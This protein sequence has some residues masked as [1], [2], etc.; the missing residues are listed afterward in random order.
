V[1]VARM[2]SLP[3]PECCD[4]RLFEQPFCEDD[5]GQDC[6]EWLCVDCGYALMMGTYPEFDVPATRRAPVLISDRSA[7]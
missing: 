4:E 7:A 2:L 1:E 5:H 3:C 6:P